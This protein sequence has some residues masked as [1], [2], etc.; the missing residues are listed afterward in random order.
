MAR[1][2]TGIKKLDSML[3]GGFP[4]NSVVL[5]SGTPG[6]GKTLMALKFLLEG[7]KNGEKCCYITLCEK[8]DALI[9]AAESVKSLQ[10][11]KGYL[12]K[13]FAIEH[14]A[15]GQ[16][17]ITMKRFVDILAN[18]PKLDRLVID[19]VNKLLLFSENEKSYR[20]YLAELVSSLR[21]MKSS[22]LLC[23]TKSDANLDAGGN[24]SFECDGILQMLFL[25]L[26]EK[27]MRALIVHKMRYT[28]FDPKVPH[29]LKIDNNDIR[30]TETK[31]I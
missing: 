5:L 20:M 23:E 1:I 28:N 29:E 24:E 17:N 4:E 10:E 12:G 19:D 31:V 16:S 2:K 26:E 22:L 18:Y 13:N 8:E 30:I 14:I 27:P 6:T 25:D 15:M 3:C 7:V 21:F 9:K 11:L